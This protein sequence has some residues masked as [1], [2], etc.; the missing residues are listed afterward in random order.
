MLNKKF[1][2]KNDIISGSKVLDRKY[3]HLSNSGVSFEVIK[4]EIVKDI[5]TYDD[6]EVKEKIN[7]GN[8]ILK[9]NYSTFGNMDTSIFF[10]MSSEG[11]K[12][13]G[14]MFIDASNQCTNYES[15]YSLK[16]PN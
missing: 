7:G 6:G 11:L 5:T 15:A 1:T 14:Q 3:L 9:I 16:A 10:N 2:I 8:P 13:L 4:T 12:Q